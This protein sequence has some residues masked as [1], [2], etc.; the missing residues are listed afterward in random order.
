MQPVKLYIRTTDETGNRNYTHADLKK[1]AD[2]GVYCLRVTVNGKRRWKSVGRSLRLALTSRANVELQMLDGKPITFYGLKPRP[3]VWEDSV[4]GA[5]GV[6]KTEKKQTLAQMQQKFIAAKKTQ[7]HKDGSSL[8]PET[9]S[10]YQQHTDDFLEACREAGHKYPDQVDGD[11]LR[12]AITAWHEDY[13]HNTVCN[14]YTSVGTFL[15]FCKIDHKDL[16]PYNE[17]PTPERGEPEAYTEEQMEKFFSVIDDERDS[18]AFEFL[19]KQGCREREMTHLEPSDLK[20]GD[21]P[22]VTFKNK[23]ALNHRTKTRKQR[24]MPIEHGLALRLQDWIRRNLGKKLVFGTENDKPDQHFWRKC[25]TYAQKAGLNPDEC[26]LHK[27]R[28]SFC[29]WTLRRRPD[30]L[31]T[32]SKWVGHSSITM[33]E[34]YLAPG[35][36]KYAQDGMQD[37]WGQSKLQSGELARNA[38]KTQEAV[39]AEAEVLRRLPQGAVAVSGVAFS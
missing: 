34:R 32:L 15:H 9:I 25:K 14:R 39:N 7:R 3:V 23:P 6:P 26:W 31:R 1:Q 18:L 36:G 16:L 2:D 21:A 22:T 8:D 37:A 29:T 10:G 13:M 5:S 17:R 24:T 28:D 27:F 35:E 30:L 33:T 12:R 19:L 11:D 4:P 38:A 20:F